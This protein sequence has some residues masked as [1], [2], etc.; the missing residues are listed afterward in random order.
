MKRM[1]LGWAALVLIFVAASGDVWAQATAQ[2]A[3]P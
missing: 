2:I 3:G 1:L